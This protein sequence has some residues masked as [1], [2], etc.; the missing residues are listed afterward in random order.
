LCGVF[1]LPLPS[2]AQKHTKTKV[3]KKRNSTGEWVGRGF[4]KCTG[5]SVDL[6][7]A[8]CRPA[9]KIDGPLVNLLNPRPTHLTTFFSLAFVLVQFERFSVRGVKKKTYKYFCKKSM[10]KTLSKTINKNFDVS[11]SSIFLFYRVLGRFSALR[12]GI[13]KT[14]QKCFAKGPCRKVFFFTIDKRNQS[15]FRVFGCFSVR[16]FQK[17]DTT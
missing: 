15:R 13:S 8:V 5:G 11:F 7:Y 16:G 1:E 9:K 4:S 3:P 14:P 12:D 6:F 17:L 2:N 10:S